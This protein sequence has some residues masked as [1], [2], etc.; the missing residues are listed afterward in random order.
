MDAGLRDAITLWYALVLGV[1]AT[2][3]AY[4]L[5]RSRWGLALVAVRGAHRL[6][7][8]NGFRFEYHVQY[9]FIRNNGCNRLFACLGRFCGF[10]GST[11]CGVCVVF[12]LFV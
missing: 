1:G 6:F 10:S 8:H 5:I 3:A 2:L 11:F 9:V 4:W 12:Q 7:G